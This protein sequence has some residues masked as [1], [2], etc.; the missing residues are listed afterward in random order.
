VLGAAQSFLFDS[1]LLAAPRAKVRRLTRWKCALAALGS[2][3]QVVHKAGI[4]S[5]ARS[6]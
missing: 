6:A 1:S 5:A 2:P 4:C 3:A